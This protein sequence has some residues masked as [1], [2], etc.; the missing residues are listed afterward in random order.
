[1]AEEIR[2]IAQEQDRWIK[3][4]CA[5]PISPT[6]PSPRGINKTDWI[7]ITRAVYDACLDPRDYR[8]KKPTP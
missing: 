3:I 5:Y 1:M 8:R 4:A 2:T 6:V 7:P